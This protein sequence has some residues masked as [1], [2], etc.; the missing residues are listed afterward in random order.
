M[1]YFWNKLLDDPESINFDP[2]I[3]D[4]PRYNYYSRPAPIER[5]RRDLSIGAGLAF[6]LLKTNHLWRRRTWLP[7]AKSV[8]NISNHISPNFRWKTFSICVSQIGFWWEIVLSQFQLYFTDLHLEILKGHFEGVKA[9]CGS[10]ENDVI[11][12]FMCF[13]LID[14]E[15]FRLLL[16]S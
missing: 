15:S 4:F 9:V 12:N 16:K 10:T 5:V 1:K 14:L 8:R 7:K 3:F 2:F 13:Q 6:P 11:L